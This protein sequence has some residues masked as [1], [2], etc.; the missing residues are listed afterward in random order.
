MREIKIRQSWKNNDTGIISY[1]YWT[2][3]QLKNGINGIDN[4]TLLADD[5]YTGIK[6]RN[7][8]EIYEGDIC[9]IWAKDYYLTDNRHATKSVKLV[10]WNNKTAGFNIRQGIGLEVIGNMYENKDLLK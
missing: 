6:D 1:S 10:E 3:D 2:L 4:H 5:L 8:T 7:G 9:R